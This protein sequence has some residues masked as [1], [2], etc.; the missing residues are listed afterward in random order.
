MSNLKASYSLETVNLLGPLITLP[1]LART[2]GPSTF[3]LLALTQA[4]MLYIGVV[5]EY[6][7][8]YAATR[9]VS[10]CRDSKERL[11]GL[12]AGVIGARIL[13]SLGGLLIAI[14][15]AHLLSHFRAQPYLFW[16][17]FYWVVCKA[18]SLNWFYRG[19][20]QTRTLAYLEII[21]SFFSIAAI[22]LL[23]RSPNDVWLVP[24]IRGSAGI[25]SLIASLILAYRTIPIQLPTPTAVIHAFKSGWPA[26]IFKGT[27][28][29][30]AVGNSFILGLVAPVHI[31]GYYAGAEKIIKALL[32][33][34]WAT[35][36]TLYPHLSHLVVISIE[37][38]AK[39]ARFTV[40]I[41]VVLGSGVA[42]LVILISPFL[43]NLVLGSGFDKAL[44]ALMVLAG[45]LPLTAVSAVLGTQW[46]FALGMERPFTKIVAAAG[47]V[48]LAGIVL[49]APY[50]GHVGV[51]FAALIA[52]AIDAIAT[53]V[54]LI[55]KNLN[56]FQKYLINPPNF[57]TD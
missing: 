29:L 39:L 4:F 12:L 36:W 10:Q 43:V 34:V 33:F 2:L 24:F 13:L 57:S 48:K 51:A 17:S 5:I 26:F 41:L 52:Q 27:A 3:G 25:I 54:L 30:S 14:A 16:A 50:F 42:L 56:P 7:F 23:I 21:P 11:S 9:E 32:A 20:E 1:Y 38:A 6:G 22:F 55:R 19:L 18:N 47:L 40:V 28:G 53:Y 44:P 15:M 8:K 31:V 45:I 49:L 37:R 35:N 46:M